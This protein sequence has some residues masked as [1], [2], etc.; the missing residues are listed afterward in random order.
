MPK[1]IQYDIL[2]DAVGKGTTFVERTQV[3]KW[4]PNYPSRVYPLP[5][6]HA[7]LS[8]NFFYDPTITFKETP[9][10]DK[11]EPHL[12]SPRTNWAA[13]RLFRHAAIFPSLFWDPNIT[14]AE[15]PQLDKWIPQIYAMQRNW[16]AARAF[17]PA[18]LYPSYFK[19]PMRPPFAFTENMADYIMNAGL[20]IEDSYSETNSNAESRLNNSTTAEGQTFTAS[21]SA[22]LIQAA[23]YLDKFGSPTGTMTAALYAMTGTFGS[24]GIPTGSAL[25]TSDPI[26]TS[27]L[28]ASNHPTLI[29]FT[30]SG[31]NQYSLVS[32]T[33]YCILVSY[34]AGN[35][36]NGVEVWCNA[37]SPTHPGNSFFFG[38]GSYSPNSSVDNIFYVY[39]SSPRLAAL[40]RLFAALRSPADSIMNAVSR[41]AT[42]TT[43]GA[44]FRSEADSI[45]NAASRLATL[46]KGLARSL[47]DS[48]MNAD[49]RL[50]TV[51]RLYA[52]IRSPSDSIMNGASRT[53][54]LTK[55]L[56]KSMSDSIMNAASRLSTVARVR[57]AIALLSDSIMNAKGRLATMK[58]LVNGLFI[59]FTNKFLK[60]NT[61]FSDKF[62][63]Q[64]T[65]F[66]DKYTKQNTDFENK[67][68]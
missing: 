35:A 57:G 47:S 32:G 50:A 28:P 30:F 52:A 10:L 65:T 58:A 19:W 3:D 44:Y 53:A 27:S 38:A 26:D 11:W 31:A 21:F 12:E 5:R 25:A 51:S 42:L 56:V 36:S 63:P 62:T 23:F 48:L 67:F 18:T 39:A 66:S 15:T 7:A 45:M 68:Q 8:P 16:A 13:A 29:R 60:Q 54:A 17:S 46:A 1:R 49:A 34:T 41:F 43:L 2:A 64:G 4:I 37:T 55:G 14:Y 40:T 9:Q 24:T 22:P 20:A 59:Q 33:N 61:S 6:N